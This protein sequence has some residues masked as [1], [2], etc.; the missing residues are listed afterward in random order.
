M[1]ATYTSGSPEAEAAIAAPEPKHVRIHGSITYVYT[2]DDIPPE[3]QP[4]P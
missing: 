3:P 4:E 1:I 2:G